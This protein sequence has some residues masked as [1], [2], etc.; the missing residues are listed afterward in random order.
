MDK[1]IPN[2]KE[3]RNN[4]KNNRRPKRGKVFHKAPTTEQDKFG[5]S[6]FWFVSVVGTTKC[7][8]LTLKYVESICTSSLVNGD[9]SVSIR[10]IDP[11]VPK[12]KS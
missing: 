9:L 2:E 12:P 1:H 11:E 5:R 4:D 7:D 6:L 3:N 10:E 8:S